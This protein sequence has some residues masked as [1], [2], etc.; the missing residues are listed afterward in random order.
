MW[1]LLLHWNNHVCYVESALF[2]IKKVKLSIFKKTILL[3]FYYQE[4]VSLHLN[5]FVNASFIA[6]ILHYVTHLTSNEFC[7][8]IC[9]YYLNNFSDQLD[10]FNR[11]P[12]TLD[13]VIPQDD[14]RQKI[15]SWIEEQKSKKS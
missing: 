5:L 13:M 8:N 10:P 7:R 11:Q 4:N 15:L 1:L 6:V 12:L 9:M 3:V 14:L 2:I